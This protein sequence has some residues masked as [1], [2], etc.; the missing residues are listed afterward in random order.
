MSEAPS[1]DNGNDKTSR[2][3][4]PPKTSMRQ[5]RIVTRHI[6][7]A[8]RARTMFRRS[9]RKVHYS[10]RRRRPRIGIGHPRSNSRDRRSCTHRRVYKS[11]HRRL[12]IIRTAAVTCARKDDSTHKLRGGAG[13]GR[14]SCIGG[15]TFNH[16]QNSTTPLK[17]MQIGESHDFLFHNL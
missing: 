7:R 8:T 6:P 17:L 12:R 15:A 2:V 9:E 5:S 14:A 11:R 3:A 4:Q 1:D 13:P 16:R 10:E